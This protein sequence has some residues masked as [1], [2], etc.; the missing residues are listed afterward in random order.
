V[1]LPPGGYL[2]LLTTEA[3]VARFRKN[4]AVQHALA[5]TRA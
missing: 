3:D 4:M 1:R 2:F 5:P